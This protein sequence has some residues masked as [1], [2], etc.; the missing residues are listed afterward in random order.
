MTVQTVRRLNWMLDHYDAA[1]YLEVGVFKGLTFTE[2]QAERKVAVDPS[3]QFDVP[4]PSQQV[5]HHETTSD[6]YFSD[7]AGDALFDV[8]F[9]DGLHT[10][11]Q[12]FRDFCNT[13]LHVHER[14]IIVI[15]DTVP[16]DPYSA[17][18]DQRFAVTSREQHGGKGRSWHG[19]T[20]KCVLAI[21]DFFPAFSYVTVMDDGNPQTVVWREPRASSPAFDRAE[22]IGQTDYFGLRRRFE[23]LNPVTNERMKE[24]VSERVL[25]KLPPRP[26]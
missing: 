2:I 19:D 12:T 16:N 18:R 23:L 11:E 6:A 8:V 20:Y 10:Y 1:R 21:H 4:P 7:I 17:L 3:F 9:L 15:D 25:S 14:S 24:L 22:H 26:R 5:E 13:I